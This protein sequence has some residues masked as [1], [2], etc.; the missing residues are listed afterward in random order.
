MERFPKISG[1]GTH[2][3][4]AWEDVGRNGGESPSPDEITKYLQG[5]KKRQ[6]TREETEQRAREYLFSC[7]EEYEDEDTGEVCYR[8]KKNPTKAGLARS[9][10]ITPETLSRYANNHV[11]GNPYVEGSGHSVVSPDDFDI[12]KAAYCVIEEFYESQLGKNRNNS[13]SIFW[14]LNTKTERWTNKQ[15]VEMVSSEPERTITMSQDEIRQIAE[16]A[17]RESISEIVEKLPDE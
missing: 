12:I 9:I 4:R 3:R 10:G 17:R 13:G 15:E 6:I 5:N 1:R 2:V 14:L 16:Q 11:N 7:L 8:W